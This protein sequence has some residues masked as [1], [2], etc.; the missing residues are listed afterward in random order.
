LDAN[1]ADGTTLARP[2]RSPHVAHGDFVMSPRVW[3][4]DA[5][6]TAVLVMSAIDDIDQSSDEQRG[7]LLSALLCAAWGSVWAQN[8]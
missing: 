7:A 5:V 3:P 6:T 4:P 8:Q 1:A 2:I